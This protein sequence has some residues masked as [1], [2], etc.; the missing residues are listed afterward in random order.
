[1][2]TIKYIR[3]LRL[4]LIVTIIYIFISNNSSFAQFISLDPE[5]TITQY[6]L[7]SWTIDHGL[8]SNAI[9]DIIQSK[10]G[11]IWIATYGGVVRFDGIKFTKYT[12]QNSNALLT[13]A[14]KL[15]RE[16]KNGTIW[17]G[18]QKGIALF[19]NYNL[20]RKAS[21][22]TL[23]NSNIESIFVDKKNNV[24]IGTNANGLFKYETDTL[25]HFKDFK[26][27]SSSPIYAIYE[28]IN[29]NIWIGTLKGE[30]IIY[31]DGNFTP[32]NMNNST[33]GIFSF[34]QDSKGAIWIGTSTG[35]YTIENEKLQKH[36]KINIRFVESIIEDINGQFWFASS[37]EGLY[38]Y[39]NTLSK[40]ELFSESNGLPNNRL[41]KIIFDHHGNLWGGTYRNGIFQITDGKFIC[42]SESEGMISKTNTAI[43][44]YSENEFWV[45]NEK[46]TIDIIK[47]GKISKLRTEI[48]VPSSQIK[49]LFK[50]SKGNVW[51]STY[52][53]ILKLEK[54]NEKIFNINNGFPDNL[55]R[56]TFEDTDGNIWVA[57]NRTGIHKFKK[58]GSVLTLNSSNGLSTDYV[59]TIIQYKPDII[60][61]GTK[62]GFNLIKND[63][64]IKKYTVSD[65]LPDNLIFNIYK[66]NEDVLWISTNS[67]ISRFE[68]NSFTNYSIENGLQTNN[69]YDI[70]EDNLGCFWMPGP[71][72]IMKVSKNQ[73]NEYAAG[74]I[75]EVNYDFYD[76][77][78]GMKSSVCLGATKSLKDSKGMLWFLTAEGIA[79]INP[80]ETTVNKELPNVY[81]E[82][83]YA[84]DSIFDL[85]ETINIH[86][87]QKRLNINYTAI[88]LIFPQKILF[89]HMLEP[90][91]NEWTDAEINRTTSYT[92]LDPGL[93]TFKVRSTNN[94]GIWNENSVSINI[95]VLPAWYQTFLFKIALFIFIFG[96]IILWYRTRLMRI[97]KQRNLLEKEVEERTHEINQQKEEILAQSEELVF[98]RDLAQEQKQQ[99]ERQ[100]IELEKH[101]NELEELVEKRTAALKI[102]KEKA[103]ESDRLKSS[104]LANMSHEIR[105][106]MN[107]IIGFSNLLVEDNVDKLTR[108][109]LTNEITKNSF[110]L[111]N[112]IE[113]ILD[114]AKIET[115]QL[116]V[117]KSDFKLSE[118]LNDIYFSFNDIIKNKKLEL[119]IDLNINEDIVLFSDSMRIKQILKNIVDNAIKF[120][121]KGSI[122]V[123]YTRQ[124]NNVTIYVKDTGIG[125]N[126]NQVNNIFARF[127]KIEDTKE[128]LYRGAGLGLAIC[129]YLSDLLNCEISV[130]SKLNKG[131]TF[132][133][134]ISIKQ[135]Q[136]AISS[137]MK[138]QKQ[139]KY[140]W[141]NK[142][143]LVAEDDESNF[144]FYKMIL[145]E[146]NAII[147][148]ART[149]IE[150]I[151]KFEEQQFDLILMDIKMPDMDGLE[152]TRIIL[153]QN[154]EVPVIA[155][156]AFALENDEKMCKDA[157]CVAYIQKPIQKNALL[158]LMNTYLST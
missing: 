69:V 128:K 64:V 62:K 8:P 9:N 71:T 12:S 97:K 79:Q 108:E 31:K 121:E 77:S 6:T 106:P 92:N 85:N 90:F 141:S 16:D 154:P 136:D 58:D 34:Y 142:T 125:M 51:I 147:T 98:Q 131:T 66:D 3:K 41:T 59:M 123:G 120:T 107:A 102:A 117:A 29:G 35:V 149:G 84:G 130:E 50:D 104:F 25:I 60:I 96:G 116:K 70:I 52:A 105:T 100:N 134:N 152:A 72:G 113:N 139:L 112:L 86:A 55:I 89:K 103:E 119:K 63:S 111:L 80:E 21:L 54:H 137:D 2:R 61:A 7:K 110:S 27:L 37:S 10:N 99:I 153:K 88:D 158:S 148:H 53:G 150:A 101:Q 38:R 129:K 44:E 46:G 1:M 40:S 33:E 14:T 157:G 23:E 135:E 76:K 49:D 124:T 95:K 42:Y 87:T 15:I 109:A 83:A 11:Y 36:S 39:N 28:D 26:R 81:I 143:I 13:E 57:T 67:G 93:Y 146:T 94:H 114:L 75:N 115:H 56:K 48:P 43:L 5:K 82:K 78:D 4:S 68:N 20:Y 126:E 65:G 24:W 47:D 155:H 138:Q 151:K 156:T 122:E 127:T 32:F 30:L 22:K 73:L 19:D 118:I 145:T 17:I 91:E 74:K 45:A 140:N 18:T 144:R 133:L 132:Y